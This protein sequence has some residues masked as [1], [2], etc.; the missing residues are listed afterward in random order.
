[1]GL[2]MYALDLRCVPG[3]SGLMCL[4]VLLLCWVQACIEGC[5]FDQFAR[6][7]FAYALDLRCTDGLSDFVVSR[8]RR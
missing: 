8:F 7:W 1:M 5:Q 6:R 4:Y 2:L 3:L